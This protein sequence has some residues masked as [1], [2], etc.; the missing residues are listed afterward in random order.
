MTGAEHYRK[1]QELLAAAEDLSAQHGDGTFTGK[2]EAYRISTWL[3][4]AQVHATL[5][6]VGQSEPVR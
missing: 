1:A 5:A 3:A 2:L 6:T 4:R